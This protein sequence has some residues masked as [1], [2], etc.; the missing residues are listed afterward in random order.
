MIRTSV[1]V[2]VVFVIIFVVPFPIYGLLSTLELVE[3]PNQE[4]PG[5]F[6]LGVVVTKIGTAIAFVLVFSL[7]REPLDKKW[8]SYAFLW[9]VMFALGEAGLALGIMPNYTWFDAG[10][11]II[12]EAIYFPLAALVTRKILRKGSPARAQGGR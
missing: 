1:A 2:V 4:S 11:G 3:I 8:L 7:A 10:G 5:A 6:M 12:A 9:W